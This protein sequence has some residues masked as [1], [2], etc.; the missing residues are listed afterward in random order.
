MIGANYGGLCGYY[1]CPLRPAATNMED[2]PNMCDVCGKVFGQKGNL[3]LH[4]HIH[5]G[6]KPYKCNMCGKTF[7]RKSSCERHEIRVHSAKQ[8]ATALWKM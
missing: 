7:N 3:L 1:D 4:K 2:N 6:E 5:T 8:N